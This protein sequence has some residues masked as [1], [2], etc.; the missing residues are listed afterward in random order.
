MGRSDTVNFGHDCL[1][2][3][4]SNFGGFDVLALGFDQLPQKAGDPAIATPYQEA[5]SPGGVGI[6]DGIIAALAALFSILT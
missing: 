4:H 2:I 5:K 1:S 3:L 6:I